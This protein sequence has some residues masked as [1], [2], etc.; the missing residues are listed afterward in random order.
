MGRGHFRRLVQGDHGRIA[1][2]MSAIFLFV[3]LAKV[4][5]AAKEMV[6]AWHYG[7][8]AIV[9]AYLFVFNMVGIPVV[10]WYSVLSTVF[11]PLSARLS[12]T[13]SE[14]ERHFRSELAGL[15]LLIG[16]VCAFALWVGLRLLLSWSSLGLDGPT[17]ALALYSVNWLVWLIP[18]GLVANYG[19]VLL[20]ADR[21]HIN[22]LLEGAPALGL[23]AVL[24]FW[25]G[26]I[27]ALLWGTLAGAVL[28]LLLTLGAL[29]RHG[30]PSTP[31]LGFASPAWHDFRA[32]IW[33]MLI[34]QMLLAL[35]VVVD[36]LFAADLGSGSIATLGYATRILSLFL[37][38]GATTIGRAMLP[39]FS[40]IRHRDPGALP[41]VAAQWAG[42]CFL[43]GA[44]AVVIGWVLAEWIVRL[45]F[46]RGAFTD[47]DTI[48]V[49]EVLQWGLL[50]MPFYFAMMAGQQALFS[51][52]RYR[53]A[54]YLAAVS[55]AVKT[56]LSFLLVPGLG[57][58]GLMVATAGMYAASALLT[59]Y[60]LM[61]LGRR[62]VQG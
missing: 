9:D 15:N 45:L 8:G 33:A 52:S 42:W 20:M 25:H 3:L 49:A 40:G 32:G 59:G 58:T 5:A 61:K 2:D 36:Q 53:F 6:V 12:S 46:E 28:H 17:H 34:A 23:L 16:F 48:R 29:A 44:V 60:A 1:R 47:E 4:G 55:L 10:V 21:R 24:I 50:Q 14:D 37:T 7:T 43:A 57:L 62:R 54:A 11:I 38:L 39:V 18:L 26:G 27:A 30:V 31:R 13:A 22:S 56:L 41:R 35:T 51:F 19:S